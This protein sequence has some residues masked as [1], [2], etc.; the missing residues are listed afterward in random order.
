[1]D[2]LFEVELQFAVEFGV[3]TFAPG[4]RA[5]AQPP[6]FPP[7]FEPEH[8]LRLLCGA[9]DQRYGVRQALPLRQFALQLGAPGT[10]ERVE[11]GIAAGLAGAPLGAYPALL[12]EAVERRI[13]GALR[14]LQDVIADLLDALCDGPA[15]FRFEGD[16]LEDE[17]I[18]GPLDEIGRF[19]HDA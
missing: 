17:E 16:G 2:L 3:D 12:F 8:R 4:K 19:A 18:E 7:T 11:F 5:D 1:G 15:V 6:D 13:E 14:D 9:D 10:G